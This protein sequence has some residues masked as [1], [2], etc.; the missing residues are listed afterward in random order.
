MGGSPLSSIAFDS[1]PKSTFAEIALQ[2]SCPSFP[3]LR[4]VRCMQ[5]KSI[6]SILRSDEALSVKVHVSLLFYTI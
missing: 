1:K 4:F 2:N 5:Q 3:T 6:E